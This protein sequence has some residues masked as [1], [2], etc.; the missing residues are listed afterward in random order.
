MK[1]LRTLLIFILLDTLSEKV[2]AQK[3]HQWEKYYNELSTIEDDKTGLS[4]SSFDELCELEEHPININTAT[5]EDFERLPFLNDKQI[6]EIC[7]Y[8]YRY[9]GMKTLGELQMIQSL[10]YYG[11]HILQ[12]FVYAGDDGRDR[13]PNPDKILKY[14]KSEFLTS[15][16]IPFYNKK[17]DSNGYLGY[18]YKHSI[19]YN[20]TYGDRFKMGIVGAQDAGEPFLSNRNRLGY[21]HYSYYMI[22]N[23]LGRVKT[24]ALGC[25][26]VSFGMGLVI[27]GDFNMGKIMMLSSLGRSTN[28]IRANTSKAEGNYMQ[29][30][31]VT[32]NITNVLTASVF[33]SYRLLDGT[34]SKDGTITTI[35]TN[36]Y[37]RTQAEMNKKHNMAAT[38]I[39]ANIHYFKNGYH[40][41]A[42]ALYTSLDKTLN[43]NTA[44]VYRR[45]YAHGTDFFNISTD[46]GYI[47]HRFSLN[48]EM[49][50]NKNNAIATI[51]SLSINVNSNLDVIGLYR[52]YSKKYTALYSNSF[53]D[54]GNVQNENGIYLGANWHP[55]RN[56]NISGYTDFAYFVWPKYQVSGSSH[57]LDNMLCATYHKD[58]WSVMARYRVTVKQKDNASKTGLDNQIQNR[59]RISTTYSPLRNVSMSTQADMVHTEYKVVEK[60]WMINQNIN[61]G[62]KEWLKL[63]ANI[64]Y[65]HTD[66]Y[67]SR[68]YIYE[69]GLL[70]DFSFPM[71]YGKGVRYALMA[72]IGFGKRV[73][74]I[75][76]ISTTDYLDRTS[77][78]NGY[79]KIHKSALTDIELQL[80]LKL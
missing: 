48:G 57:S 23:G 30:A 65:F 36:G 20:L 8:L 45:F 75:A 14:G 46:Y 11:R 54:G 56:F 58:N 72:K 50:V 24:L 62:I 27:N 63:N 79:Q 71:L 67:D 73:M 33:A 74:I 34:M 16:K 38:N 12:C 13:F 39:G 42:T 49:A 28:N 66:G 41:G 26:K 1:L 76:K 4:Q 7:E 37:H 3:E 51:N 21:D 68:I 2:S 32:V 6:E 80:R 9:K 61:Y 31:A 69:R 47:C 40:I 10:D 35:I 77:I 78:G 19:R 64:G 53:S 17:G 15:L 29:G 22:L 43:P 44:I 52:Y 55:S 25:Y 60:G 70:Y 18:K 5:R 59:A